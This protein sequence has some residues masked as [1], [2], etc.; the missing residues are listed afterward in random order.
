MV[1]PEDYN[2]PCRAQSPLWISAPCAVGYHFLLKFQRVPPLSFYSR[3]HLEP[4]P[5]VYTILHSTLL[6][7]ILVIDAKGSF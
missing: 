6:Q 7:E 5:F 2:E 1:T 4:N 3:S